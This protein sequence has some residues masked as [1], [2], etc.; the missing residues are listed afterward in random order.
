MLVQV[1]ELAVQVEMSS[2]DPETVKAET[3]PE[4]EK[5]QLLDPTKVRCIITGVYLDCHVLCYCACGEFRLTELLKM[6]SSK[7]MASR[8]PHQAWHKEKYQQQ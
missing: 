6:S 8:K 5:G 4:R 2:E 3:P 7:S 1:W